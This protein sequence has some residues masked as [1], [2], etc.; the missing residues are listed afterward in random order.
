MKSR[1]AFIKTGVAASVGVTLTGLTS[2]NINRGLKKPLNV[3]VIGT[4]SRGSGI[5]SILNDMPNFK[6]K[7]VCDILPFRLEKAAQKTGAKTY[8]DY[9]YLLDDKQL[10]AIVVATPFGLHD[11]MAVATLKSGKHIYCEKTMTK[12]MSEIQ[13]VIDA[14]RG[15]G[16]VF[17]TGH[18]YNSSELYQTSEKII[19]SGYI[20]D[21][22]GFICQWNRNGDWRRPVPDPKWER[23]I[24]WRMYK[25]HSGGLVAE[26]CSHQIDFV[27]RILGACPNRVVGFG[28]ID[29]W[30]DGRETMDNVRVLFEYPGGYDASFTCTTTNGYDDYKIRI[31]GS[32]GTIILG[33]TSGEIFLEK[34]DSQL[35]MV[36]GVS[37]ATLKAWE[38][39]EGVPIYSDNSDITKQAF[40]QFYRSVTESE[41][42]LADIQSGANTSK[43]VQMSLDSLESG[44]V[45]HWKAYPELTFG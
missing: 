10:D 37:G 24:N 33:P 4:G 35:G 28:G 17:Q 40:E 31:M 20:G 32:K 30:K 21:L 25:E 43:C 14:H 7:A 13:Q 41:R 27:N 12:G 38:N 1:R 26:L 34:K 29:H 15:S 5:I 3:G 42:V 2:F 22:T 44:K 8:V 45:T 16:L 39:G 23:I 36:D 19:R 18:Q 11:E 6:V 9:R